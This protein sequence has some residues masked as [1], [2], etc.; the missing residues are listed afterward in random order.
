MNHTSG[1]NKFLLKK[2]QHISQTFM[3]SKKERDE[4]WLIDVQ[5]QK[6]SFD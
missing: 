3:V 6:S 4:R 5:G 1:L 2:K